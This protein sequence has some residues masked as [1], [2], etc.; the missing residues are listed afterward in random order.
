MDSWHRGDWF[1]FFQAVGSVIAIFAAGGIAGYQ[2]FAAR[3]LVK[4]QKAESDKVIVSAFGA[5]V[6][7]A[8]VV[9]GRVL[10]QLAHDEEAQGLLVVDVEQEIAAVLWGIDAFPLHQLPTSWD[11][12]QAVDVRRIVHEGNKFISKCLQELRSGEFRSETVHNTGSQYDRELTR[13]M[14]YFTP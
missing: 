2:G 13:L 6:T 5:L 8:A 1:S 10:F 12:Y 7:R 11:V 14:E 9:Y 3:K 4:E